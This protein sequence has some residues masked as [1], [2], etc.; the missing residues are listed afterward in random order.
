[1]SQP[2]IHVIDDDDAVRESILLLLECFGFPVR[3]YAS[4]SAFL[5]ESAPDRNGCLLV[6][7]NMPGMSGLEL[8]DRLRAQGTTM[9]AIIMTGGSITTRILEALHR[10]EAVLLKKPFTPDELVACL[11]K[12]LGGIRPNR[13]HGA[14]RATMDRGYLSTA[15]R[16]SQDLEW[17]EGWGVVRQA[18]EKLE[19]VA[20]FQAREDAE[21][22]A[23]TAGVDCQVCWLSYRYGL[24]LPPERDRNE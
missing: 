18:H 6:D 19:F 9:P 3:S 21:A 12:I 23:A 11:T 7:V 24:N 13:G 14:A 17:S 4:S 2:T 20:F 8:L 22:A 15:E 16:V 10:V 1:M 5:S